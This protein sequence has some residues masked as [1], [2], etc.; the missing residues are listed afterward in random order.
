MPLR[1]QSS[2]DLPYDPGAPKKA[3]NLSI[4]RDLLEKARDCGINLS[5]A[6]EEVL[7][8]AL[9]TEQRKRWLEENREAI[10]SYN[11]QVAEHG[12]FS[13]GFRSF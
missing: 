1:A 3:T 7:V 10:D 2:P 6:L 12:V 13:D 5:A 8:A 9:R 11:R 4:N